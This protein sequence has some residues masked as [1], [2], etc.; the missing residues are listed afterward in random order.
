MERQAKVHKEAKANILAQMEEDTRKRER[1][2]ERKV[3]QE[4]IRNQFTMGNGQYYGYM[5]PT[6][7]FGPVDHMECDDL[8][9][10]QGEFK[11]YGVEIDNCC[12]MCMWYGETKLI[13]ECG[14]E[15]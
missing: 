1:D 5:C 2:A 12:P 14:K 13:G 15:N 8:K 6:C 4:A 7:G 11:D 9:A 10:H 3:I